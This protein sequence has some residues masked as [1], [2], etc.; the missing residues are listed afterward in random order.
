MRIIKHNSNLS[1]VPITK[2]ARHYIMSSYLYYELDV[3]VLDDFEF[4]YICKRLYEEY[5]DINPIVKKHIDRSELVASTGY[6]LTYTRLMRHAAVMW[7]EEA[8]GNKIDT[9]VLVRARY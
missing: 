8:T 4:N 7:Y 3:N 6:T 5:D 1:V 9:S 2:I